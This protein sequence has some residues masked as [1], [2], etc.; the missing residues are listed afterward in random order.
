MTYS[1][2]E[3]NER[4]DLRGLGQYPLQT[5]NDLFRTFRQV[6][7]DAYFFQLCRT[8]DAFEGATRVVDH[9]LPRIEKPKEMH[10][11]IQP[12]GYK[13]WVPMD[14][15]DC[16]NAMLACKTRDAERAKAWEDELPTDLAPIGST[17][18]N[19]FSFVQ[20]A[21]LFISS[22]PLDTRSIESIH[23]LIA[24]RFY[25]FS[26]KD[27]EPYL[28]HIDFQAILLE[29]IAFHGPAVA[30]PANHYE[31]DCDPNHSYETDSEL[32]EYSYEPYVKDDSVDDENPNE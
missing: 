19:Y 31:D 20:K 6:C 11:V 21:S 12:D 13:K 28:G 2:A 1:L 22:A 16:D 9:R 17:I 3:T 26:G 15:S 4:F 5:P 8:L 23:A 32:P 30:P 29:S 25:E 24:D 7:E 27:L 14:K 18:L 10:A